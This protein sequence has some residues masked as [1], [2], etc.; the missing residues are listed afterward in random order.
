MK[1]RTCYLDTSTALCSAAH[2][3]ALLNQRQLAVRCQLFE[4][5]HCSLQG[6]EFWPLCASQP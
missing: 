1:Q 4:V 6:L 3:I 5:L 2:L